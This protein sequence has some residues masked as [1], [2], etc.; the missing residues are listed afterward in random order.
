MIRAHAFP[1]HTL[2]HVIKGYRFPYNKF[3]TLTRA[4]IAWSSTRWNAELILSII[5]LG[6]AK[7]EQADPGR[8]SRDQHPTFGDVLCAPKS[9]TQLV[10]DFAD[11]LDKRLGAHWWQTLPP[12]SA[13]PTAKSESLRQTD[14]GGGKDLRPQRAAFERDHTVSKLYLQYLVRA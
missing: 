6:G 11:D 2:T 8:S 4:L 9:P 10:T 7:L 14:G 1:R 13:T 12:L 3:E 5:Q